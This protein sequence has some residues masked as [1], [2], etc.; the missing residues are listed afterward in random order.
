MNASSNLVFVVA[1]VACFFLFIVVATENKEKHLMGFPV[2]LL[3][4]MLCGF[5]MR[6]GW[7]AELK[8]YYFEPILIISRFSAITF[9]VLAIYNGNNQFPLE[10]MTKE[11]GTMNW[12]WWK[13]TEH[14]R[15][16][17]NS[18]KSKAQKVYSPNQ[19][20]NQLTSE[21]KINRSKINDILLSHKVNKIRTQFRRW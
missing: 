14:T 6:F 7:Q 11:S 16:L 10:P 8:H 1:V 5:E 4:K 20:T 2:L 21:K 13:C 15:T 12:N 18:Y 9:L 3:G 19:P 17:K